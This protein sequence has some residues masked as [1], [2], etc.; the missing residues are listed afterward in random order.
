ME[1]VNL[2]KILYADGPVPSISD[3][4]ATF[5]TENIKANNLEKLMAKEVWFYQTKSKN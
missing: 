3:N 2:N 1:N 5:I 4:I